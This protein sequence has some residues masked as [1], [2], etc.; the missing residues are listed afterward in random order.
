ML[1]RSLAVTCVLAATLGSA[2]AAAQDTVQTRPTGDAPPAMLLDV[3]FVPQSEA[4]CG[5]AAAA[6]RGQP[7]DGRAEQRQAG[8][9]RA[10]QV[11]GA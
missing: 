1:A 7:G 11:G 10:D 5:G 8:Q 3:P 6:A 4:L 9:R 2:Q